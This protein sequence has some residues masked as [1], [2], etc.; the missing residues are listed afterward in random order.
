MNKNNEKDGSNPTRTQL[1]NEV[2][3]YKQQVKTKLTL[4]YSDPKAI[5][6]KWRDLIN[7]PIRLA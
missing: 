7:Q 5:A 6:G 2:E 1:N 4:T 3:A